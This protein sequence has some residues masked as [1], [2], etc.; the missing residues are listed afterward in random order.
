MKLLR[1]KREKPATRHVTGLVERWNK[2]TDWNFRRFL[3][4]CQANS[5]ICG[6][7]LSGVLLVVVLVARA[8]VR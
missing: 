2:R 8:V 7:V 5:D 3:L 4:D 1:T 6:A